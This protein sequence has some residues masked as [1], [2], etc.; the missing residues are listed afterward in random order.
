MWVAKARRVAME[1][2]K[3]D[4]RPIGQRSHTSLLFAPF[5]DA[6]GVGFLSGE[7]GRVSGPA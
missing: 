3:D 2:A 4:K 6:A 7:A 1:L 5:A